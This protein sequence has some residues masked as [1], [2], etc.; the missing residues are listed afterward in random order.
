MFTENF[1]TMG[2]KVMI[3]DDDPVFVMMHKL[4]VKLSKLATNPLTFLNGKAAIEAIISDT[5]VD[6][7]YLLLL[8]LNMPIMDGWD[9]LNAIQQNPKCKNIYVAVISSTIDKEEKAKARSYPQVIGFYEKALTGNICEEI[10]SNPN[11]A[12]FYA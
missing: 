4:R 9:F 12:P 2:L 3:V 1:L 6:D 7:S 5:D 8:D 11:I 10:K